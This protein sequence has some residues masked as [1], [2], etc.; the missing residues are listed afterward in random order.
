LAVESTFFR[1]HA[2]NTRATIAFHQGQAP[3]RR[4]RRPHQPCL[5]IVMSFLSDDGVGSGPK[6]HRFAATLQ[7]VDIPPVA[8]IYNDP[9]VWDSN[10]QTSSRNA[11]LEA[12]FDHPF[13]HQ[14]ALL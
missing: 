7:A 13:H 3:T 9:S 6:R 5:N 10:S 1:T 4:W 2:R 14:V 11:L 8:N 12:R